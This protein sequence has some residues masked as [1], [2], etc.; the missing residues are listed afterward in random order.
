M[1]VAGGGLAQLAATLDVA[2]GLFVIEGDGVAGVDD[3]GDV[4]TGGAVAQLAAALEVLDGEGWVAVHLE[5]AGFLASL[6][7]G[8][9]TGCLEVLVRCVD[10][11]RIA[12]AVDEAQHDAGPWFL[13][14]ALTLQQC[15]TPADITQRGISQNQDLA[16]IEAGG[17]VVEFAGSLVGGHCCRLAL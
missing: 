13:A 6:V 16:E 2:G 15:R 7:A 1:V 11:W 5:E 10:G 12:V 17:V 3:D 4:G 14:G 9:L 8:K